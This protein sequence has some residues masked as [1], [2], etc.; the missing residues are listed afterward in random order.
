[1]IVYFHK[2]DHDLNLHA[3][4]LL[5]VINKTKLVVE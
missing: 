5:Q 4:N 3:T 2:T 1:M